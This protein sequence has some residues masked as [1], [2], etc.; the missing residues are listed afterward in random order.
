MTLWQFG[1]ACEGFRAFHSGGKS[2]DVSAPSDEDLERAILED[3][4]EI[5]YRPEP[6]H[7]G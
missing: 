4:G 1:C 5:R 2:S 6:D 7:D 3:E